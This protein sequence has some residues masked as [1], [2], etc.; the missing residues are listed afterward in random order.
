MTTTRIA[1]LLGS[2]LCC[3]TL[4][5]DTIYVSGTGSD[6]DGTGTSGSPYRSITKALSLAQNGTT[7]EVSDGEYTAASGE[8]FPLTVDGK[9]VSIVGSSSQG[10]AAENVFIDGA[11]E[12]DTLLIVKNVA[13]SVRVEGLTFRNSKKDPLEIDTCSAASVSFCVFTQT[14]RVDNYGGG[15]FV[16][17]KSNAE[18][19]DCDFS[20][21][22][23]RGG[24]LMGAESES[25]SN[26]PS[27]AVTNCR[28]TGL[29]NT[30]GSIA[31]V[32]NRGTG[33]RIRYSL[34][35]TNTV[36]SA[37]TTHSTTQARSDSYVSAVFHAESRNESGK[38]G[39]AV[40]SRCRFA[41]NGGAVLFGLE[42]MSGCTIDN[43]LFLGNTTTSKGSFYGY[44]S[45][46]DH[47]NNTFIRNAGC[48]SG[49]NITA[50]MYNCLFSE[51]GDLAQ[52]MKSNET[53]L[54]TLGNTLLDRTG[55]G[56][57]SKIAIQNKAK[58]LECTA[59]LDSS[60][61]PMPYSPAIDFG[62]NAKVLGNED[63]EGRTRVLDNTLSG[64]ATV[65]MGCFESDFGAEAV[66]TFTVSDQ[67]FASR[68]K[69]DGFTFRVGVNAATQGAGPFSFDVAYPAG[70]SGS[71]AQGS[72][73]GGETFEINA[74]T[75]ETVASGDNAIVI[76]SPDGSIAS[77]TFIVRLM[78]LSVRAVEGTRRFTVS[79]ET[80]SFTFESALAGA[81]LPGDLTITPSISGNGTAT[82]DT[83]DGI[84][85]VGGAGVNTLSL[86]LNKGV[87]AETGTDTLAVTVIS[88]DGYIYVDPVNGDDSTVD[89]ASA[90]P[91]KTISAAL[92][93]VE[94]KH[95]LRLKPGT[96]SATA[97]GEA[98]PLR[99][100]ASRL[101][102][103]ASNGEADRADVILDGENAADAIL[104][105]QP[106]DAG[107]PGAGAENCSFR[108]TLNA[109]VLVDSAEVSLANCDFTQSTENADRGGAVYGSGTAEIT[110]TG[111]R[112]HD[113]NRC[114]AL[115]FPATDSISGTTRHVTAVDCLF[116]DN[117]SRW[118]AV[119]V[120][121]N[122]QVNLT[123]CT[124]NGNTTSGTSNVHDAYPGAAV[125]LYGDGG[126]N[127]PC[128]ISRCRFVNNSGHQLFAAEYTP[129]VT[130]DN[131]LIA[132][133]TM[134]KAMVLGY[135][136]TWRFR[137]CTF[138]GNTPGI[139]QGR[140]LNST[141]ANS[142]FVSE[143]PLAG[144][145]EGS[146]WGTAAA[147]LTLRKN[148]VWN[149]NLGDTSK[150]TVS[151]GDLLTADPLLD[152][153]FAPKA[154][155]PAVDAALNEDV[156]G[157]FD[158]AG[159]RRIAAT[160]S[161]SPAV[162][163]GAFECR[164]GDSD[165]PLLQFGGRNRI[166]AIRGT[167]T[168]VQLSLLAAPVDAGDVSVSLEYP[169]GVSGP[170]SVT[171]TAAGGYS[172]LLNLS[173]S[174]SAADVGAVAA[175]CAYGAAVL[176][177]FSATLDLTVGGDTRV[178]VRE[179]ST[180]EIAVTLALAG[181]TAPDDIP[182][183]FEKLDGT[184]T[185]AWEGGAASSKIAGG[186]FAATEN[187]V[188]SG[189]TGLSHVRLTAPA[190]FMESNAGSV[191]LT[192]IAHNGVLYV[193]PTA[194]GEEYGT[195]DAPFSSIT[196]ALARLQS[197]DTLRLKPG[198]YT[199]SQMSFPIVPR[200]VRLAGDGT[201]ENP[202]VLDG[203]D[204]AS[205]VLRLTSSG[206]EQPCV[207]NLALRNTTGA[208][209]DVCDC[210]ARIADCTFA[211][212]TASENAHGGIYV[213]GDV[214]LTV[215]NSVF[216]GMSRRNA[217]YFQNGSA[218]DGTRSLELR[219]C[220][221]RDNAVHV[222][223]LDL[224]P[225][226]NGRLVVDGCRF[227]RNTTTG[228]EYAPHDSY[229]ASC[230][231]LGLN[232]GAQAR[233]HATSFEGNT[234]NTVLSMQ[235]P[236]GQS[237]EL[238]FADCLFRTNAPTYA[239]AC[240]YAVYPK[241]VNNTSIGNLKGTWNGRNIHPTFSNSIFS[242]DASI[243][244][245][246]TNSAKNSNGTEWWRESLG[247]VT[248]SGKNACHAT[249]IGEM[250]KVNVTLDNILDD[251]PL[252]ADDCS[253]RP[254]SPYVDAGVNGEDVS[255]TDFD[256]KRRVADSLRTGTA[257][258]D[259]GCFESDYADSDVPVF[260]FPEFAHASVIRGGVYDFETSVVPA[261]VSGGTVSAD[262]VAAD[263]VTLA[264]PAEFTS[265]NGY[266]ATVSLRLSEDAPNAVA[267]TLKTADGSAESAKAA[268]LY[269]DIS[270]VE[271]AFS[272]SRFY[273][274]TGET[275]E[276]PVQMVNGVRAPS[277]IAFSMGAP[278]GGTSSCA[279][280]GGSTIPQ[281]AVM[282]SGHLT[283]TGGKGVTSIPFT[284][285][286]ATFRATGTD[287][288]TIEIV[289][290]DGELFVDAQNGD[291]S[292]A[293]GL[294][295]APFRTIA[296]ALDVARAGDVLRLKAG[297]YGPDGNGETLPVRP[298][299]VRLEADE[300]GAILDA[301][302]RLEH[303]VYYPMA[304]PEGTAGAL[305]G[306]TFRDTAG[307][308]VRIAESTVSVRDCQFV[309]TAVNLGADG[310]VSCAG[311]ANVTVSN[312]VF[313]SFQRKSAIVCSSSSTVT[314]LRSLTVVDCL[315]E[316]LKSGVAPVYLSQGSLYRMSASR[317]TFRNNTTDRYVKGSAENGNVHDAYSA[318][319]FYIANGGYMDENGGR[320]FRAE[321]ATI[322]RC[323]FSGGTGNHVIG[324]EYNYG[325]E[326]DTVYGGLDVSNC[327]FDNTKAWNGTFY[328]YTCRF[329]F[330]N[331]TFVN[332]SSVFAGRDIT[333]Y[334]YN[335]IVTGT[336]KIH[337]YA[338]ESNWPSAIGKIYLDH[339]LIYNAS[340]GEP[341]ESTEALVE[342]DPM[343]VDVSKGDYRI[344]ADSPAVNTGSSELAMG[345]LD[346]AGAGR[347][348][349]VVD[350]GCHEYRPGPGLLVII[351]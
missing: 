336:E 192:V 254:Y 248:L 127:T 341:A 160:A 201:A 231:Y 194:S 204:A 18:I 227:L 255:G 240:G 292:A 293:T 54:I 267:V 270:D 85:V 123:G 63:L 137:N 67:G 147:Q 93:A 178:F 251:D 321:P 35:V 150:I 139:Y 247:M 148:L 224:F 250:T 90:R 315:F 69:G 75:D 40:F 17:G 302:N 232:G 130:V 273:V 38:K 277:E 205:S 198:V 217:V 73:N 253:L 269:L 289:A 350:R 283:V 120:R 44:N 47:Y 220:V 136:S 312:C 101:I 49:R 11:N 46:V 333:T 84:K 326:Y 199:H 339:T 106:D 118:G 318:T 27:V 260:L 343:Y 170:A 280:N 307:A 222:A 167:E 24:V 316:N 213:Y 113:M 287:S 173:V 52:E 340:V 229:S 291:D 314:G 208:A 187:L 145:P 111:C 163:F 138:I 45:T 5:A 337:G 311:D 245:F 176:D 290:Y 62:D 216:A 275:A 295:D 211:Q 91:F 228:G 29:T 56:I 109:A 218:G 96:Y 181:T 87:F 76:S 182:L 22:I 16:L 271:L 288:Q 347:F 155:S 80:I 308:A 20:A 92:A 196:D 166:S 88:T 34:A 141:M 86:M 39:K 221:F 185:F 140:N 329:R 135:S 264:A 157:L 25:S 299:A 303:A 279:W 74:M 332:A 328:G 189:A 169:V 19:C 331:C 219:G 79:G 186:A 72:V 298:G 174:T 121:R 81:A 256:G 215:E 243:S 50:Q 300:P 252:F 58:V 132:G 117:T 134:T 225:M 306:L 313:S 297:V 41:N 212:Q 278:A 43:S 345:D 142:I 301:V 158:L 193:A 78:P 164:W 70:I 95:P 320:V 305:V 66:P 33:G 23:R 59:E 310:G 184:A 152:A 12:K 153:S 64:S 327:L 274:R 31:T 71:V 125:Y 115:Y 7:I 100:G 146:Q 51:C 230:A 30:W 42:N 55:Y 179:G 246:M 286:E 239:M 304:L 171:L 8:S 319:A 259:L 330:R 131:S 161:A 3:S 258:V 214:H 165:T 89:G 261:P 348:R 128:A 338:P 351:R 32:Q 238:V 177:L 15:V 108:N 83:S 133:N 209:V 188:V 294:A 1:L 323:L 349:G 190:S 263:G 180:A 265:A 124:F 235:T 233:F 202:T 272:K 82:L 172:A 37:C 223:A 60:G 105:Y 244:A 122:V 284:C 335:C 4:S 309:Q 68:F 249:D 144:Y 36:F 183:Q 28:F 102:G 97:N 175:E 151:D 195:S 234:G 9:Q 48:F 237:S 98:F 197:G 21:F 226:V 119:G 99:P 57:M 203:E 342:A 154:W 116:E 6:S 236:G 285:S 129:T 324:G 242:G 2:A 191:D 110:V 262:I 257:T 159:N 126:G 206:S 53:G 14:T 61:H 10:R 268:I 114:A 210:T 112:F 334:L 296:A 322:D 143:G 104:S 317:C 26:W 107:L 200:G 281:G 162:D 276:I 13:N 344:M 65:D 149:T 282:S 77:M 103:W 156:S 241:F 94:A 266:R 207:E 325:K 346:F 168:E